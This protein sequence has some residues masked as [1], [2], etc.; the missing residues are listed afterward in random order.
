MGTEPPAEK[1][2]PPATESRETQS[3]SGSRSK[4]YRGN[5]RYGKPKTNN[6]KDT[7]TTKAK[8]KGAITDLEGYYFDTGPTQAHDFKKTHKKISTYTGTKYSAEVMQSL[9]EMELHDWT[10]GMP[11][12]PILS[13]FDKEEEEASDSDD[14]DVDTKK[15]IVIT[16]AT[17]IPA[18]YMDRYN[19]KIKTHCKRED[20]FETDMQLC[21]TVI[22]SMH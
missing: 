22:H 4:G 9:E 19:H 14:D 5:R 10:T 3:D 6:N 11:K 1:K 7:V 20:K 21:Y 2:E 8:F 17:V 15:K 13:D 18:E 16:K 12:K